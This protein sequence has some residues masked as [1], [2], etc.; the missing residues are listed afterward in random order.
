MGRLGLTYEKVAAAADNILISGQNPTIHRVRAALGDT[1]SITT[2]SKYLN[3]W[4]YERLM[5]ANNESKLVPS[6][7]NNPISQVADQVWQQLSEKANSEAQIKIND[8]EQQ[9]QAQIEELLIKNQQ[10]EQEFQHTKDFLDRLQNEFNQL[11]KS[12]D[13]SQQ[14]LQ[15]ETKSNII[16]EERILQAEKLHQELQSQFDERLHSLKLAHEQTLQHLQSQFTQ[17][18]QTY[19]STIASQQTAFEQESRLL[20]EKIDRV[21]NTAQALQDKNNQLQIEIQ[22]WQTQNEELKNKINDINRNLE[23]EEK[24]NKHLAEQL[25]VKEKALT[26]TLTKLTVVNENAQKC[27]HNYQH[28]QRALNEVQHTITR[29]TQII[30]SKVHA[31]LEQ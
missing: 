31:E 23:S 30:E 1:G 8:I 6:T 14:N 24:S 12:Y 27:E 17:A 16:F 7:P 13:L 4:K 26:E 22:K 29:L 25:I 20:T 18:A 5:R 3:E 9:Y 15:K 10:I 2:I 19:Q 11:Q 28:T 21:Q